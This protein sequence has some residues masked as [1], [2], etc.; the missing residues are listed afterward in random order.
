M[1]A[2]AIPLGWEALFALFSGLGGLGIGLILAK[3]A[4]EVIGEKKK[5]SIKQE[6]P[7]EWL[8]KTVE[9]IEKAAKSGD[10]TARKAKKL[11]TDKRF[12]K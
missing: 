7:G 1:A 4:E 2:I 12:D 3:T 8:G 11:L 5:G 9:D 6:F 10:A